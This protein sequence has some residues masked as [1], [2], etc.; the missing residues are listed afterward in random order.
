MVG[1]LL[2]HAC[3]ILFLLQNLYCIDLHNRHI[4]DELDRI[5]YTIDFIR[6]EMLRLHGCYN[7]CLVQELTRQKEKL[8]SAKR[9]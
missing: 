3:I 8:T 7:E 5:S 4:L 6:Q 1:A 2:T 9:Y